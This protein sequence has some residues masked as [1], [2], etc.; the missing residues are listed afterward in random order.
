MEC[1]TG[2]EWNSG[3]TFLNIKKQFQ[4]VGGSKRQVHT[5]YLSIGGGGGTNRHPPPPS[6]ASNVGS[7]EF[8]SL[9][10]SYYLCSALFMLWWFGRGRIFAEKPVG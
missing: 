6:F 10:C 5:G 1:S 4:G 3:M 8:F 2:T 9:N 7:V